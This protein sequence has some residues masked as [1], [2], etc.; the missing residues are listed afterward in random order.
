M[1]EAKGLGE[2]VRVLAINCPLP[3][4]AEL[5]DSN[6]TVHFIFMASFMLTGLGVAGKGK[7]LQ[8]AKSFAI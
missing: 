8:S 5:G 2:P 6:N 1:G 3:M 4:F 7:A